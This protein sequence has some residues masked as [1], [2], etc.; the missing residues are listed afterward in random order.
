MDERLRTVGPRRRRSL[1]QVQL[2]QPGSPRA[3]PS[4]QYILLEKGTEGYK[5]DLNNFAPSASIAWRPNVQSGFLRALLGDPDQATFRAGYSEAYDRQGLTRFTDLYGGNRGGIDLADAQ[6]QHRAGA[7]RANRGRSCCRRP[8]RLYPAPFNPDP[9]YPIAVGANRAD[10]LNAFAP[11]IKIARVRNWTVGFARSISRDMAVEIRYV[12][13]RGDNEWSAINYNTIR[14]ENLVANGFMNEF[15]LA[16]A[17]LAANNASGA[18]NRAGSFAYFGA[19]TGTSPLPIYLAYLNGSTDAGNPAAYANA[20]T[21]WANSDD[22]RPA[23]GAEPE[24]DRGGGRSRRQP[25]APQP[26]AGRRLPG[27]LLRPQPRRQRRQRHRQ[28]RVQQLQRAAAR[29]APPAVER[30]SPRT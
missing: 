23:R 18:S 24:P 30:A 20:A 27:E 6:R 8:S 2:P 7:G 17:N 26:G 15:K 22:R 19:G 10:S 13:N 1:Q 14:G 16:M 21:T 4:P 11:D 28:R 25:D 12:G 3:A 29:A 5:T 9:T